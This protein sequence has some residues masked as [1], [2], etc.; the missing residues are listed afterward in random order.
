MIVGIAEHML[1]VE[2]MESEDEEIPLDR[3]PDVVTD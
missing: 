1:D 2:L 3:V